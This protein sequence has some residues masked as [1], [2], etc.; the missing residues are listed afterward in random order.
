MPSDGICCWHCESLIEPFSS[1][2]IC[3]SRECDG[4]GDGDAQ[5][6]R[7]HGMVMLKGVGI[8]VMVMLKGV[9]IMGSV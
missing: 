4:D 5:R 9:C 3:S 8:M 7:H 2:G 6:G 1:S